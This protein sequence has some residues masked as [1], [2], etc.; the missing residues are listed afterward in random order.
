MLSLSDDDDDDDDNNHNKDN[1]DDNDDDD[2]DDNNN[3]DDISI[4]YKDQH[5][6]QTLR[7]SVMT[8]KT[9]LNMTWRT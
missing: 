9:Q 5:K 3:D 1:D 2:D 8:L 4:V 6:A 7:P